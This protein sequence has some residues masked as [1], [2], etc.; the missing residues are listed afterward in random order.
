MNIYLFDF[1]NTIVKL[2]YE[3][4]IQYL[5][6]NESLDPSLNFKLIEKTKQDYLETLNYDPD[7]LFIILSNRISE[8]KKPLTSLLSKLG[9]LFEDYYLISDGDRSKGNRVRQIIEKYPKCTSIKFWEDKDK[10][11]ESVM[12]TMK[13]HPNIKL[14]VIKTI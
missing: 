10:H 6:Q 14:E 9:Y 1:D 13:D 7:G 8:V 5:D 12:E 11:I 2:P 4:T 3:E